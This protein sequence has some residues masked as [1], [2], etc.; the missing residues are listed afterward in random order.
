MTPGDAAYKS[1][2]ISTAP[3]TGSMWLFNVTREILRRA[4]RT[5]L[6][7]KIPQ[8]DQQMIELAHKWA[9]N[10]PDPMKV[11]VLKVHTMLR[12]DMPKSRILTTI[13]DPRDVLVSF[14]LFMRTSFD[15]AL[16]ATASVVRFAESYE[17]HPPELLPR[18]DY[19]DIEAQPA[20][21]LKQVAGF[22][23]VPLA[24]ATVDEVVAQFS[25]ERVRKLIDATNQSV[26]QR[27]KEKAPIDRGEV[28]LLG[29]DN[30]RAFDLNTGFQTGHVSGNQSGSWRFL[31]SE[32]EKKIVH[33]RFGAW[34]AQHGFQMEFNY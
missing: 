25:R 4:G 19:R 12:Q 17:N 30:I 31:L 20:Q 21:V 11:W 5:V 26:L 2:W 15:H 29:Q 9:W 24:A 14:R 10:D 8:T 34:I 28:V 3:R 1:V 7:E 13:R 33:E 18:V 16:G 32:E 22:L 23:Q 27:I 6:P